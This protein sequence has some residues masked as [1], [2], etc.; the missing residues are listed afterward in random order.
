LS[1]EK[2]QRDTKGYWLKSRKTSKGGPKDIFCPSFM[3]NI[4]GHPNW[5]GNCL[6]ICLT[7]FFG[8]LLEKEFYVMYQLKKI[9]L[10]CFWRPHWHFIFVKHGHCERWHLVS[11]FKR[12]WVYFLSIF[13]LK[14]FWHNFLISHPLNTVWKGDHVTRI[15]SSTSLLLWLR[16]MRLIANLSNGF[17]NGSVNFCENYFDNDSIPINLLNNVDINFF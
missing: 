11:I 12:S 10:H 8:V 15:S 7:E 17:P 6:I 16:G 13:E 14:P 2:L 5:G 9:L 1:W 4:C 3:K